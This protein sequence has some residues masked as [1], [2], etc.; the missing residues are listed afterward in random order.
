M[1]ITL[2][3]VLMEIKREKVMLFFSGLLEVGGSQEEMWRELGD[4]DQDH[5]K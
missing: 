3:K 4:L 5:H 1:M 2:A